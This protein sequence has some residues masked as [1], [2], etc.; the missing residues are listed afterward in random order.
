M[1][2]SAEIANKELEAKGNLNDEN[3]CIELKEEDI[4]RIYLL[5]KNWNY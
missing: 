5:N 3:K 2:V 4:K 1:A